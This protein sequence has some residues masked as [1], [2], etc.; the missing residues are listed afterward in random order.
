VA[1]GR[2]ALVTISAAAL[3]VMV[4]LAAYS[5]SFAGVFVFDDEPAIEQNSNLHSLWPLTTAMAAPA[6]TTLAGRPVASLSFAIDY[7]RSHGSLFGYHAGNLVIHLAASLLLFGITRRTLLTAPLRDR[8]SGSATT[9]AL[10]VALCFTVHPLQTAS[11]TYIVQ[12]VESLMGMFYLATLYCAIR[13]LDTNTWTRVSWTGA[14]ILACALGMATKEV[15]ATAPLMV[16]L[17]DRQFAADRATNRRPLY[18]GLAA[19]WAIPAVLLA[20][21]YRTSSVG[22]GFSEWPWWRYLA[23]QAGV[24]TTYLRLA[25]IPTPLVLDYGWP[26]ATSIVEVA[27]PG[28]FLGSL[29]VATMWGVV[30]SFPAAFAGAWCF[31]ILAPS[32]SVIPIVTEVAAEHRMYLPVAGVIALVVLGVFGLGHRLTAGTTPNVR[33]ALAGAGLIAA[34]VVIILFAR[35]TYARNLDYHDYDRI[36]SDTIAKRPRN[37]RARNN[38]ATS[39]LTTGRYAEAEP[40]LRIAVEE[41]PSFAEAEANLGIA[42]SA[43]GRLAEGEHHL[44]RAIALRPDYADAH[45]NLGETYA[46]QHRLREAAAQYAQALNYLPDDVRLL[47]RLAWILATASDPGTRDGA[48]ARTF[49]ERAVRITRRG[50]ATALESLAAAYAELG[51]FEIAA[52]TAY[53]AMDIARRNGNL[54]LASDL[55]QRSALY[56]RRQKFWT[57]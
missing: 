47:N 38:Y 35:M 42:L 27:L 26:A 5:N 52:A 18:L 7:A 11:V 31:V 4:G 17:W 16:M 32:S 50:N 40:H 3:I 56:S 34:A 22:F 24:V 45:R 33:R 10:I 8:F 30:R 48:R 43:Q 25:V 20:G 2:H 49:A 1:G 19:T 14:S 15:M 41:Q 53:E 36:W 55:A 6:G 23:T 44:L 57:Q 51:E 12:R 54:Q 28:V 46:L 37:A 9:L 21:A 29:L 39:L 13:A